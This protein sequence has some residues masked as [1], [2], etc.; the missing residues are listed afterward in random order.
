MPVGIIQWSPPLL[1]LTIPQPRVTDTTTADKIFISQIEIDREGTYVPQHS[2]VYDHTTVLAAGSMRVWCDG[3]LLGDFTSVSMI[4][5]KRGTKHRFLTL[6]PFV[7]ILCIHN[8]MHPDVA[9]VLEEHQLS[10]EDF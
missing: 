10:P 7:T 8:A 6:T 4:N 9:A 1:D 5:I 3:E 2:H